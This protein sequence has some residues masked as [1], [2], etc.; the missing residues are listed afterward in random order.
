MKDLGAY[1]NAA[2]KKI[3]A[4]KRRKNVQSLEHLISGSRVSLS[5]GPVV[6]LEG[7]DPP[8]MLTTRLTTIHFQ[9]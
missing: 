3:S 5:S 4:K 9:Q 7:E 8:K 6:D 2:H 1:V